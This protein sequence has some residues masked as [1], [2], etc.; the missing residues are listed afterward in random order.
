MTAPSH[1]LQPFEEPTGRPADRRP[2]AFTRLAR[3]IDE[4]TPATRDRS[5]DA[6]RA[7]A[8]IGV[9]VGHWL[10]GALV[11]NDTGALTISSPLKALPNLAPTSWFLQMLGLFFLV[12]GYASALSWHRAA[13]RGETYGTWVRQRLVRLGRPVVAVTA[14]SLLAFGVLAS[15][16]VPLGSLRT[17][18]VLLVQP[19]WFIAVYLVVTALTAP[20]VAL[21]RRVGP[22]AALGW[23]VVVAAVDLARFGPWQD[24]VPSG[25]AWINVLTAWLFAYQL[26]IAWWSGR[27]T[28]R[29][30]WTTLVAGVLVFFSLITWFGYPASM[31]GVPGGGRSNAHPASLLVVA[32]AAAQSG[33]AILVRDRIRALMRRPRL[34]AVAAL[35]NIGAMSILCWHHVALSLV[36]ITAATAG[37]VP[38]LTDEPTGVAWVFARLAWFPLLAG[39]LV[40]LV[41]FAVRFDRPWRMPAGL[42]MLAGV[43]AAGFAVFALAVW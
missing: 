33:A 24:A 8:L 21:D 17:W 3:R 29:A 12:G 32:L 1:V 26:G 37:G 10:V 34:W 35:I 20:M 39:V 5:I 16:D 18:V 30:V 9:V 13:E 14:V 22:W 42:R 40:A 38:G 19:F 41:V 31:V 23:A 28:R 15:A 2:G 11:M 43:L 4:Q 6:L 25:V 27:L 36:S 7:L